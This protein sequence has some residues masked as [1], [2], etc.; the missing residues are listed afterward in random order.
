M[1]CV[2][3]NVEGR[4]FDKNSQYYISQ[5]NIMQVLYIDN[6]HLV[7]KTQRRHSANDLTAIQDK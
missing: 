7:S 1:E 2:S 6:A 3:L 5:Y 4:L